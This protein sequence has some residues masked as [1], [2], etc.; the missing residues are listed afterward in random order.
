MTTLADIFADA[1]LRAAEK[2]RAEAE[3]LAMP[4]DWQRLRRLDE[5]MRVLETVAGTLGALDEFPAAFAAGEKEAAK[6]AK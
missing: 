2:R 5:E 4:G 3:S 1:I 6:A